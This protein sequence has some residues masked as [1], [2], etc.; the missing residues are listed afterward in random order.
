MFKGASEAL[1]NQPIKFD[2]YHGKN[3]MG[4]VEYWKPEYPSDV[5]EMIQPENAAQKIRDLIMKVGSNSK[6]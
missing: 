3:G 5:N 4:N 1:I 2:Y 6:I